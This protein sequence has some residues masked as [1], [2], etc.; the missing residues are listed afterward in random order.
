MKEGHV[1]TTC[2]VSSVSEW[3]SFSFCIVFFQVQLM[4]EW[5][6][7]GLEEFDEKA[8]HSHVSVWGTIT[9]KTTLE[10]P[11]RKYSVNNASV[12]LKLILHFANP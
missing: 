12:H 1:S 3:I 5:C 6:L 7:M 4:R 11:P 8:Q 10:L 9:A 2:L